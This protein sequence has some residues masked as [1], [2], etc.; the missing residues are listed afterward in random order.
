M[1]QEGPKKGSEPIQVLEAE[2]DPPAEGSSSVVSV[3]TSTGKAILIKREGG[4]E[5]EKEEELEKPDLRAFRDRPMEHLQEASQRKFEVVGVE[6]DS[7]LEDM[8][9]SEEEEEVA[10]LSTQKRAMYKEMKDLMTVQGRLKGRIPGFREGIQML[11]TGRYP[12]VPS[13][14]VKPYVIPEE[15]AQADIH[16]IP[17]PQVDQLI[18]SHDAKIPR[19][20]VPIRPGRKGVVLSIDPYS[21]DELY[22]LDNIEDSI[23]KTIVLESEKRRTKEEPQ[24]EGTAKEKETEAAAASIEPEQPSTSTEECIVIPDV[25]DQKRADEYLEGVEPESDLDDAE[26]I[27]STSAADYDRKEAEDLLDKISSCHSALATHFNRMNEII[28]RMSKT[29]MAMYLG[30]VHYMSLIKP[31]PGVTEKVYVPEPIENEETSYVVGPGTHEEKLDSLVKSTPAWRILWA[32]ALGDV[33]INKLSQAQA[34]KKYSLAK[35]CIQRML[36]QNPDHSKGGKQ[37]QMEAKKRKAAEAKEE[38]AKGKKA[39]M[40][41][42][43]AVPPGDNGSEDKT[44]P[45]LTWP[46]TEEDFP[47]VNL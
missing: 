38:P 2:S 19:R 44:L 1:S 36:S 40:V 43:V 30:K 39:K 14:V 4:Q 42:A 8:T 46:L 23:V 5:I 13:D 22:E 15:G 28:L 17:P 11:V 35:T 6:G 45:D 27:S 32:V 12:G 7:D 16:R 21:D 9:I 3:E 47:K 26:T 37:Y 33:L 29:Q 10:K 24:E 20:S 41:T 18:R 25:I 31:K 34:S